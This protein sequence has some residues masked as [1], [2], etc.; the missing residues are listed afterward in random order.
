MSLLCYK[1][2]KIVLKQRHICSQ[3]MLLITHM[4]YIA[5]LH[6]SAAAGICCLALTG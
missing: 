6:I 5:G 3:V 1:D 2:Y 4:C